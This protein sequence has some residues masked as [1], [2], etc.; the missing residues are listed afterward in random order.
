MDSTDKVILGV[1]FV[2]LLLFFVYVY[3]RF[4]EDKKKI[5]ESFFDLAGAISRDMGGKEPIQNEPKSFIDAVG[6]IV[7][8][9]SVKRN[10][11][12][13]LYFNRN[14]TR[15]EVELELPKIAREL[16]RRSLTKNAEF[17][18]K[19]GNRTQRYFLFSEE[20]LHQIND[21]L[22]MKL[23]ELQQPTLPSRTEVDE[24]TL[25][26]AELIRLVEKELHEEY[27]RAILEKKG[28]TDKAKQDAMIEEAVYAARLKKEKH[29]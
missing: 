25:L 9:V 10:E 29:L 12:F 8:V 2:G 3:K 11:Q 18:E 7:E 23:K 19:F 1:I 24:K 13:Q 27:L 28:I 14:W 15:Q 20:Q 4:Q 16:E 22:I 6:N 5:K 21:F 26:E 17:I